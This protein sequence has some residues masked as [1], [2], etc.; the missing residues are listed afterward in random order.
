VRSGD[1]LVSIDGATVASLTDLQ[2]A[3]G[4]D[5]I[6]RDTLLT[7]IRRGE[8]VSLSVRPVEAA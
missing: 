2:R 4:A 5:R 1:I 3:L 8:R 7:L 6:G